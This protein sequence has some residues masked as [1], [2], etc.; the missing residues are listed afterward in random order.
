M[1]E[2]ASKREF[3]QMEVAFVSSGPYKGD[4][5]DLPEESLTDS[6]ERSLA[7]P[8]LFASDLRLRR[9][10]EAG[11]DAVLIVEAASGEVVEANSR[12]REWLGDGPTELVGRKLW[13]IRA[14]REIA[15]SE[16]AF[17]EL[18]AGEEERHELLTMQLAGGQWREME[19]TSTSFLVEGT[20]FVQCSFRDITKRAREEGERNQLAEMLDQRSMNEISFYDLESLSVAY[21]NRGGRRNLGYEWEQLRSMTA[22]EIFTE[23]DESAFGRM[24]EPLARG[25]KMLHVLQTTHRRRDG[26]VYPVEVHLQMVERR[27][28]QQVMAISVDI[29]ERLE[30][31]RALRESEERFRR[32][33]EGSPDAVFVHCEDR[34]VF[35]NPATFLLFGAERPEQ[36]LG[37]SVLEI[38]HPDSRTAMEERIRRTAA[39]ERLA[40]VGQKL[41][42]LD[43]AVVEVDALE[44]LSEHKG[45]PA[46]QVILRDITEKKAMEVQALRS[47]RMESIGLL[48]AGIAH[49]LNNALAPVLMA[50]S[51]LRRGR[52]DASGTRM[53]DAIEK[54]AQHAAA[55]VKQVLTFGRGLQD[56]R[57]VVKIGPLLDELASMARHTFPQSIQM[58][59]ISGSD[60]WPVVGNHTQL[61][62][63][64]LNLCINARD[65]MPEGGTLTLNVTNLQLD[66]NR[67]PEHAGPAAG[68]YVFLTV[69]DTGIGMTEE[70]RAHIFDPFYTTKG[71]SKGTG[72]GLSTVWSIVQAHGGFLNVQS[73]VG[74]GSVFRVYLPAQ[75]EPP[76][77]AAV[78]L[79]PAQ[80]GRGELILFVDDEAAIRGILSQTLQTCGYEVATAADGP[81]AVAVCALHPDR[82]HLL[83]T[84]MDMPIMDGEATI[85]AIR[86]LAP[87]IKVIVTSGS[88]SREPELAT[89]GAEAFLMKPYSADEVLRT[90]HA[91][92]HPPAP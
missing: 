74:R 3:K 61:H 89:L 80:L 15:G 1:G 40:A 85:M 50:V 19:F 51:L 55:M 30:R 10:F 76:S 43:G 71:A 35:A 21:V 68:S 77:A 82:Y 22:L 28:I 44:I 38:M 62:Q 25:E 48:A 18:Q 67:A 84:D 39:G 59:T 33:V 31:E 63:I 8:S 81:Q 49:D 26:S 60:L 7:E 27:G 64:L 53:L 92:L 91:V 90:V 52:D 17:A 16:A 83:I 12:A 75:I 32:L 57:A 34:I 66:E 54:S 36:V 24:L 87:R 23:F 2:R 79:V 29:T 88:R 11:T 58:R 37:R 72:L 14:C 9:F 73:T 78:E 86:R 65:A 47:Q 46:V 5:M 69:A 45:K 13:E 41:V 4:G 56:E 42:R 6:R 70:V 20:R